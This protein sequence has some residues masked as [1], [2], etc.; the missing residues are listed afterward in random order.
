[1]EIR[2]RPTIYDEYSIEALVDPMEFQLSGPRLPVSPHSTPFLSLP[3]SSLPRL[4]VP[5]GYKAYLF[6]YTLKLQSSRG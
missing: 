2:C 4:V 3:F 5:R 1:M 6:H